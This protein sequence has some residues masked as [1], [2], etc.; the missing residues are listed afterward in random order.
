MPPTRIGGAKLD[1]NLRPGPDRRG[2]PAACALSAI[3]A[4]AIT[5]EKAAATI[6]TPIHPAGVPV[7]DRANQAAALATTP[8]ATPAHPDTAVNDA[9]RSIVSRMKRRLSIAR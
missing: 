7:S 9:E 8:I 6:Q 4:R 3:P 2:I 5:N 1:A